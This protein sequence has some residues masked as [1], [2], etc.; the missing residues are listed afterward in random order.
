MSGRTDIIVWKLHHKTR[1]SQPSP[2][3]TYSIWG[4][5]QAFP[6]SSHTPDSHSVSVAPTHKLRKPNL[7]QICHLTRPTSTHT[8]T[9]ALVPASVLSAVALKAWLLLPKRSP[10]DSPS[11]VPKTTSVLWPSCP[12][13]PCLHPGPYL[14]PLG[15][16]IQPHPNP[17]NSWQ[18]LQTP[19]VVTA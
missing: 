19:V 13:H 6:R 9:L 2:K 18:C 8:L 12:L 7:V 1:L 17:R 14:V 16:S 15:S 11:P 4:A 3:Q 10:Y 5:A